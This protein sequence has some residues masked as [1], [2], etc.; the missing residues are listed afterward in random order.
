MKL[1]CGLL[2]QKRK[3][4]VSERLNLERCQDVAGRIKKLTE[5]DRDLLDKSIRAFVTY[6]RAYTEHQCQYIFRL[7]ELDVGNLANSFGLLRLPKMKEIKKIPRHLQ[8]TFQA[9]SVDPDTVP[10]KDKAREKQRGC[11]LTI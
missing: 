3:V 6:I 7:K 2:L 1:L 11:M 5:T 9:S 10:Y 8:D 4:P